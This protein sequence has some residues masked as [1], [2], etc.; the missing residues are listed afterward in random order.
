MGNAGARDVVYV[1]STV[2]W[3]AA[4]RRG[5]FASEDR[6][7]RSLI[8]SERIDRLVICN[9]F[10]SLPRKLVRSVLERD[11]TPFPSDQ[12]TMLVEPVRWRGRDPVSVAG[13]ERESAA[14]DRALARAATR[15]GMRDP[16]L[17]SGHPVVAGFAEVAWAR[18]VTWY[19]TDDWAAHPGYRPW[20]DV[21][22]E[23]Y[24]RVRARERRVAA[25]SDV[26]LERLAPTGPS[27]VIPNGLDPDEWTGEST[28]PPWLAN[29]SRPVLVY[30]GSLDTRLDIGWLSDLADRLPLATI[31]LVGG[32]VD[33]GHLAPLR[34][35]PNIQIRPP[36][37]RGLLTGLVRGSDVG[38]LPHLQTPLTEAM[39]PLKLFEYLAAGLPVAATDLAPIRH[40][41]H[42]RVV[43]A[44]PRGDFTGAVQGAIDLGHA[45]EDERL[46]FVQTNSWRA[47]HSRLL[48]LALA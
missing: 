48:D 46:A 39:S 23:S 44:P 6:L 22:R 5:W 27:A 33:E 43:L 35:R 38:L 11:Q 8:A 42:P 10:R 41:E 17:I 45:R 21:Y 18:A 1:F 26:L 12:R 40:I 30:A 20:R 47:R 13:A 9:H 15:L 37:D 31:V 14:Y 25:V 7:V 34:S 28:P 2:T 16:V 24:A 32:I 3:Q 29:L 36:L 4:A 19:A